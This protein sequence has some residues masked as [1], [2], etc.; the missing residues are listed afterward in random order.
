VLK[1][2]PLT[3]VIATLLALFSMVPE[4]M[5]Q[6]FPF[7]NFPTLDEVESTDPDGAEF[8]FARLI[9]N[10]DGFSDRFNG[11]G[12]S[13]TTD[14]PEAEHFFMQG[15][16]RLSLV[17]GMQVSL[18]SGGGAKRL[19]L[20]DDNV[21]DYPFI[22]AVEVGHW[23]LT[24]EEAAILREY[25][26][27][28][29]FLMLDDFHGSQEWNTFM[30]SMQRVFPDRTMLDIKDEDEVLHV[31]YDLDERIQIPGLAALYNGVTYEQDGVTP[32]WRGIYDDDGRLM[33]AANHNMDLG[34][35]LEHADTPDY[36]ENMT[37]MAYR[38]AVNYVIYAMTH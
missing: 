1:K 13:W 19:S 6:R 5:A 10:G 20:T 24:T 25:L 27:R 3:A 14:M 38:F 7:R 31:L 28:G 36:P 15:L 2:L 23:E 11:R 26:L 22:Y 16:T 34:D 37:A 30:A 18:Y 33:V 9:Y 29:G 21:F 4:A 35:A 12:L 8:T 32:T 17:D